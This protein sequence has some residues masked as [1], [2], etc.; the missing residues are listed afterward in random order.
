[1]QEFKVQVYYTPT[2]KVLRKWLMKEGKQR[3]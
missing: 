2:L 1:M 3:M